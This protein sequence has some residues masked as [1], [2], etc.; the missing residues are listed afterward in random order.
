[1]LSYKYTLKHLSE[2]TD[3]RIPP[4][5]TLDWVHSWILPIKPLLNWGPESSM[6]CSQSFTLC[7]L[8]L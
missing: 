7:S 3:N 2:A 1:M 6:G 5:G 4:I 8:V